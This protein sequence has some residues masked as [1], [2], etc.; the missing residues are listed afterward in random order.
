M[1]EGSPGVQAAEGNEYG[2]AVGQLLG[3]E[4]TQSFLKAGG[5][6][7]GCQKVKCYFLMF[8][9]SRETSSTHKSK[10]KDTFTMITLYPSDSIF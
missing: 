7:E 9:I 10:E 3:W 6:Y 2:T 4:G 8:L 1:L 5:F